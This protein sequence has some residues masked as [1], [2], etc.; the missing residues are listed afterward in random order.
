MI[1]KIIYYIRLVSFIIYIIISILLLPYIFKCNK[2][3]F[4]FLLVLLLYIVLTAFSILTRKKI[5]EK[6]I[7]YNIVMIALAIYLGIVY[8]RTMNDERLAATGLYTFNFDYCR[9]N[10]ILL[11]LVMIGI[12]LNTIVLYIADESGEKI[13]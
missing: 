6:T 13:I 2:E 9:M 1:S 3:G 11:G 12:M 7:S 8:L 4:F 10:F 5:Y